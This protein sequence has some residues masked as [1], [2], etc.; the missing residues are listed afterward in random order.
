MINNELYLKTAFCCMACD[1]DI[2]KEEIQL[3]KDYV[4]KTSFFDHI[5]VERLLNEYIASINSTGISFLNTF[6]KELKNAD[7]TVDQELDVIGIAINMIEADNEIRYQEIKFFKRL[8]A[9]L[10]LS[11]EVVE[12]EFPDKEDFFLPDI[13]PNDDFILDTAFATINLELDKEK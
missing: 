13:E 3:I 10:K 2:A 6:L 9:C 4:K 7:L 8:R 12:K 1:G 11:D 5:D